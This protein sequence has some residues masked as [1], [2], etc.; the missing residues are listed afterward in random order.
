MVAHRAVLAALMLG[1]PPGG[2]S[3]A[4]ADEPEPRRF[5]FRET[6]MGS[7]FKILLY[8]STEEEARR[9]SRAAFD[10]I[11]ALDRRFSDYDPTSELMRL[12]ERSGGPPVEVSHDLFDILQRCQAMYRRSEGL[13]D[14][15]I[16][17]VGR[18]WRR[19]RRDRK[20]PDPDAIA[21]ARARVGFEH[22][23][24]DPEARTV[25]LRLP[26]M[27]LDLGG[28]A[29]GYASQAALEVLRNQGCPR[30][31][32]AGAG[33]IV[34]GD[35]PPDAQGWTIGVAPLEE[36]G[37]SRP[38]LFLSVRRQAVSTSGDAERFV[39]IDGR[40][41]S[42]IVDPRIGL[43]VVDRASVTVVADEGAMADCLATTIYLLGTDRGLALA[44]EL[45]GVAAL[46]VRRTDQGEQRVASARWNNLPTVA[47]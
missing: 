4:V 15:T 22:V 16:G 12:C 25:Q 33:D 43:G 28:I 40:R 14:V 34:A 19:A 41:Y 13:F 46:F 44:D 38:S 6:H 20:L 2:P 9:A 37:S 24:L 45:P 36:P 32:V 5:E 31:L 39:E 8:S 18:L 42:H 26:D 17:P 11:A 35:P 1:L 10:R 23:A 27:K 30:A 47:P 29:K 3:A 7:E 21:Q